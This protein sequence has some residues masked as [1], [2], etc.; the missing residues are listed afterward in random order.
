MKNE[1]STIILKKRKNILEY[2]ERFVQIL[3][4]Q[5]L[6]TAIRLTAQ[7]LFDP[8]VNPIS[9]KYLYA[10]WIKNNEPGEKVL[11][12]QKIRASSLPNPFTI[13]IV[14]PVYNPPSQVL[15]ETLDSVIKQSYPYW[16]CCLA[17]GDPSN[18][19]VTQLIEK[20]SSTDSRFKIAALSENFG[21]AGN[22]NCAV[23][24]ATGD[25]V[26]FLDHDDILAPFALFEVA[27]RLWSDPEIDILY[28]DEDNVDEKGS[29][30]D[31]FFKPDFSPDLL[32]SVNYMCH[33][34]V[35]RK[36]I[37]EE[38][39][40]IRSEF[41][42]AQ[43]F[44]FVLRASENAKK[45]AHIPK[46]LYH[47]RSVTGSTASDF[48]AKPYAGSS[49]I[50]A[51]ES[52]LKRRNLPGQVETNFMPTW[53][54]VSYRLPI[55]PLVSIIILNRDHADDLSNLIDSIQIKSTYLNF[56]ILII[57]NNSKDER[58]F[59]L[60]KTLTT[61]NQN[62]RVLEW[63]ETF[64]YSKANNYASKV[65]NGDVLLFLNNDMEIITPTW[66]EE[67]LMHALRPEVGAV[68]AKL[69]Y[70]DDTIQHAGI[71]VG[72]G[73][74]AGHGHKNY[75]SDRVGYGGQLKQVRNTSA[76]TAAC[77]MIRKE[78]F[79]KIGGFD[80]NFILAFGDVDLGLKILEI[81]L[82]N[83]WTPFAELYH[84]ESKTRGYE[85]TP[86]QLA[87]YNNEVYY[88]RQKWRDFLNQGDPY[89]NPNLTLIKENYEI[90][91]S[92]R[93]KEIG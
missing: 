55:S 58:L 90:D 16:E 12:Q 13:S 26:A 50:K 18:Q 81:G 86:K 69:L 73:D 28:S 46:I 54:R 14:I 1:N 85:K 80:E 48:Y 62:I 47:W 79:E 33:F 63:N 53:Y 23:A 8:S 67:L 41:E 9:R 61:T 3:R 70:P 11:N 64:N 88:F 44:D 74:V 56:E 43:D 17:N 89:Y 25:Y 40:W 68:G 27:L 15:A 7:Y 21:I 35:V 19:E 87:R 51:L 65:A 5:G 39:G 49:G 10:R 91:P 20:Y 60:Y 29:R 22:T 34:L 24:L 77:L 75:N 4:D 52:R 30:V 42:G 76:N 66:L 84:T 57:E 45:I 83:V 78:I 71:V 32:C 6:T 93:F 82:N 36:K 31:P 92:S 59:N 2:L 37:G 72:I 38:I